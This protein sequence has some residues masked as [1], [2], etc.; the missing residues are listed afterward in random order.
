MSVK[1]SMFCFCTFLA[2]NLLCPETPHQK[3]MRVSAINYLQNKYTFRRL[4]QKPRCTNVWN[5]SLKALQFLYHALM[6]KLSTP[7]FFKF[8]KHLKKR[9]TS[10]IYLLPGPV[11]CVPVTSSRSWRCWMFGTA[12]HRVQL[13]AQLTSE[14]RARLHTAWVQAQRRTFWA[15][16]AMLIEWAVLEA[17]KH[18]FQIRRMC[19]SNR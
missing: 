3:F 11:A 10:F 5:L 16:D 4:L 7:P 8:F 18:F 14:W 13:I 1:T 17:V 2:P 19:F 12:F 9:I 6:T 15:L